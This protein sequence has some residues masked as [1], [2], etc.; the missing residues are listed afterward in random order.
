VHGLNG[1]ETTFPGMDAAAQEL[2]EQNLATL[3]PSVLTPL[4]LEVIS[5][6]ATINIGA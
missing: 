4:S 6:Q 1:R 2:A 3:D 5:R